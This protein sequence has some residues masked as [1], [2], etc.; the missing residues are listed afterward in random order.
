MAAMIFVPK[1]RAVRFKNSD[2]CWGLEYPFDDPDINGAVGIVDGRY[3][4][5]GFV[6]NEKCKEVVYVISGRGSL[7]TRTESVK[8]APGDAALIP[9]GESY[10]FEGKK[11]KIFMPCAPAW[12]PEQHKE[13]AE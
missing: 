4:E 7:S 6:M 8:L 1:S 13:V 10:F 12:Y 3:P 5:D 11:L 2:T 9:A